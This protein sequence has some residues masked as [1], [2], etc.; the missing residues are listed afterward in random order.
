MP[1]INLGKHTLHIEGL[2]TLY[3]WE[4]F[5][6]LVSNPNLHHPP[7]QNKHSPQ[8]DGPSLLDIDV[9]Y[10]KEGQMEEK[11]ARWHVGN[12]WPNL[13]P[14]ES[15]KMRQ[16]PTCDMDLGQLK[17]LMAVLQS[18]L[19]VLPLRFDNGGFLFQLIVIYVGSVHTP[20]AISLYGW[21]C[22]VSC[23]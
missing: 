23:R 13:T 11:R 3:Q 5:H 12:S 2:A 21:L 19:V 15:F 14:L 22:R 6:G 10:G 8:I 16:S 18:S 4:H 1:P 7:T 17:D 20:I 9:A